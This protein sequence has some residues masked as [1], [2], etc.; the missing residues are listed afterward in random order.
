MSAPVARI[1]CSPSADVGAA[2]GHFVIADERIGA[3]LPQDEIGLVG[4]HR[5]VKALEHVGHFLAADA[6]IEHGNLMRREMPLE[7]GGQPARI[8]RRRRTGA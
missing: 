4:D 3:E 7:F 1:F 8:G 5:L 6:A 2:I